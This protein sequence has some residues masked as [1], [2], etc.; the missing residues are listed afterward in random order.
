MLRTTQIEGV[1]FFR[2]R[3]ER[4]RQIILNLS[5][6]KEIYMNSDKNQMYIETTTTVY[7]VYSEDVRELA[8]KL[9]FNDPEIK[10]IDK[11]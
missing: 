6:V 8:D 10:T 9:G 11:P 7:S 4:G 5:W 2:F 1:S 3:E